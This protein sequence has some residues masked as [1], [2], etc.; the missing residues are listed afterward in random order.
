MSQGQKQGR[1]VSFPERGSCRK[2]KSLPTLDAVS[3]GQN[4]VTGRRT[5]V[6]DAIKALHGNS[7]GIRKEKEAY[8]PSSMTAADTV[9][10]VL[11]LPKDFTV[12]HVTDMKSL[13]SAR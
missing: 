11:E 8:M 5:E 1:I 4:I 6:L 2:Q 10:R 13:E 3:E 7:T 12:H 9:T